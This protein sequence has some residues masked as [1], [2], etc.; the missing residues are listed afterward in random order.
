[1]YEIRC[2]RWGPTYSMSN[3]DPSARLPFI[4]EATQA[5]SGQVFRF[6]GETIVVKLSGADTGGRFTI[7]EETTPSMS[8]PPLH[9]HSREDEWLYILEGEY[10]VQIGEQVVLAR[11][12]DSL[13]A[14]RNIPHTFQNISKNPGRLLGLAEPSG[15]EEFFKEMVVACANGVP[16]PAELRPVFHRYG[17]ELL[18][19]PLS[20][21]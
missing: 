15:L 6:L 20:G 9:Q 10:R 2:G 16:G 4:V 8:G 14:P 7:V 12:G 21:K 17:L 11:A 1:M 5:R 19:P 3:S 18:G 13:F